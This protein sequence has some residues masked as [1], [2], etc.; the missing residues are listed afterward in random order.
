[1]PPQTD[2]GPMADYDTV[3]SVDDLEPGTGRVVEA[4]GERLA[5]FNVDG[6][7]Y[8]IR[9]ACTHVGGSL[10][11]G[12]LDGTTV[13]CPL[14]GSTFDVTSGEHLSPP[15]HSDVASYAVRVRGDEV[16]VEI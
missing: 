15:A 13:T 1:M 16:Q 8:A 3:A 12:R 14:H 9:N 10:G 5:L 11:V 7:F 2:P 6:E 4:R